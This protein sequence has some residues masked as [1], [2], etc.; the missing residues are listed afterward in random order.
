MSTFSKIAKTGATYSNTNKNSVQRQNMY[1]WCKSFFS[2]SLQ[3]NYIV[4]KNGN[5]QQGAKVSER[6]YHM[7]A[8]NNNAL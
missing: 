3:K 4:V 7:N 6:L 2:T 5:V 1:I 8:H